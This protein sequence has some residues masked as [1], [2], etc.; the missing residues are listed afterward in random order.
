MIL[1]ILVEARTLVRSHMGLNTQKVMVAV[2]V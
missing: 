2:E 1:L